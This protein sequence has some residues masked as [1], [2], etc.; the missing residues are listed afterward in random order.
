M[1]TPGRFKT[2]LLPH[3]VV[4]AVTSSAIGGIIAVTGELRDVLGFTE[5]AIGIVVAAGFF[6]SFFAQIAF[7]RL[8]DLGHGRQMAIIGIALSSVAL[9]TMALADPLWL[10]IVARGLLGFAVGLVTPGVRRAASVHNP[11]KVGENLGRLVVG[12]MSGFLLG[13]VAVA[14]MAALFGFRTPFFVLAIGMA[15]FVPI[16][17]RL[18]ADSGL[19][20]TSGRR[21][22]FDLLRVQ[23]LQGALLLVVGYFALIGAWE[24]VMPVMFAD[25][26]G[27]PFTTGLAFTL[28]GVPMLLFS[29]R[30]GRAADRIGPPKVATAGLIVVAV[31]TMSYGFI[32]GIALLVAIMGVLGTADAFGF[33]ATQVAVSRAVPQDRQAAAL[34]LM[35]ATQVFAAGVAAFPA[36]MLYQ[37]TG[38]KVTWVTVGLIMLILIALGNARLRGTHPVSG[39]SKPEPST[40]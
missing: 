9:F 32:P 35:G 12:D 10:W 17:T 31:S 28:L 24:A 40:V 6:G 14:A 18:P 3:Q 5:G 38:D 2:D 16:V 26:G 29:T 20:D 1:N 8:A 39:A 21:H 37:R 11:D 33:T 36:A 7:S 4:M 22:S 30:A 15:L 34:G 27:T 13:P 19:L 25:R 23:R